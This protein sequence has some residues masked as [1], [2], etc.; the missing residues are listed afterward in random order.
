MAWAR[1][2]LGT[3][4]CVATHAGQTETMDRLDFKDDDDDDDDEDDDACS[5]RCKARA[6]KI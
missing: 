4:I 6:C 1:V 2:P 5:F 3:A